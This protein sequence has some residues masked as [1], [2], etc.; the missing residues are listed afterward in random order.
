[1]LGERTIPVNTDRV[2]HQWKGDWNHFN[3]G[4][5]GLFGVYTTNDAH[6]MFIP[7][8]TTTLEA[9][10]TPTEYELDT[11]Q[12]GALQLRIDMGE[13][14]TNDEGD[15]DPRSDTW[16]YTLD[17]DP[18]D[19]GTWT[20]FDVEAAVTVWGAVQD[21]EFFESS[22]PYTVDVVLT[23]DL[24][25]P[26]DIALISDLGVAPILIRPH[27]PQSTRLTWTDG[28]HARR[29]RSSRRRRSGQ[30][31]HRGCDQRGRRGL[32]W[33]PR[34]PDHHLHGFEFRGPDAGHPAGPWCQ[35]AGQERAHR[36]ANPAQER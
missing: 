32:L 29:V 10:F 5:G 34:R 21:S 7:N 13:D 12:V 15:K 25:E 28:V 36:Y 20:E 6:H 35:H 8:G 33:C 31:T 22:V 4:P 19:W 24:S 11:G 1:M 30:R 26:R 9:Y 3:N 18:A 14:G 23:L 17:V 2:G 27:R 16:I